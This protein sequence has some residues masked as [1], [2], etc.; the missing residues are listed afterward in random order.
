MIFLIT[1]RDNKIIKE[2]FEP[3]RY[4]TI[5]QIEKAFLRNQK[6]S[7]NIARRRLKE[8]ELAELIK[9]YHDVTTN[10]NIYILN[11]SKI[12]PPS[13][14]RMITLDIL[15]E[16]KYSGFNIEFFKIEMPWLDGKIVSDAF[17]IFTV[18][19]SRYYF[20]IE[21]QLANNWHRLEKYDTLF[22]SGEV[23][24]LLKKNHFPR[25]LFISDTEYKTLHIKSTEIVHLNT[26]LDI[27]PSI[28]L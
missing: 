28:L 18:K 16:L 5:E 21:V 12:K 25:I 17:I 8:M 23:Q 22:E 24:K 27:F 10:S 3:Y 4:A 15:A 13:L 20:F 7:Y 6:Y 26:N 14:H 19:N 2:W 1:E 11:D 9:P